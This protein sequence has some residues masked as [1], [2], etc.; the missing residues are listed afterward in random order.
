MNGS[1][2]RDHVRFANW[3]FGMFVVGLAGFITMLGAFFLDWGGNAA[4]ILGVG[5]C[6]W[7]EGMALVLGGI[8]WR[9]PLGKIGMAGAIVLLALTVFFL[10]Q[11][12]A[13]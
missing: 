1:K 10:M 12:A 9:H 3:A 2:R 5:L 11:P 6:L 13:G 8:G 4:G 7:G